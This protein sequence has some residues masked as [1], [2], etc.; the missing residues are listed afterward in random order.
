[1]EELRKQRQKEEELDDK[2]ALIDMK[3]RDAQRTQEEANRERERLIRQRDQDQHICIK[4]RELETAK[5]I[6]SF[7]IQ[8]TPKSLTITWLELLLSPHLLMEM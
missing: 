8:N 6:T 5:L 2:C 3:A 4:E 7:T 1:M